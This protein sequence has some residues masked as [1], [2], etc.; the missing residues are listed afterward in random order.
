[1]IIM[2]IAVIASVGFVLG[3]QLA[4][5]QAPFRYR[6]Y[7][8]QSSAASVVKIS[9]TRA[10]DLKTLH[11]RP[12]TIQRLEWRAP[13]V[14]AGTESADPVREILFSFYDDQLY[15]V[16]VVYDRDRME[17]LT[18]DDVIESMSA[19]YGVP[20]LRQTRTGLGAVNADVN[21]DTTVVA[22]W[23]DA[24]SLLT[25]TRSTYSPQFQL[26][27]MSKPLNERARAA[28]KEALRLDTQEA[29]QREIDQRKRDVADAHV[30]SQKARVINKAAFR[31]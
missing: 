3:S 12:S 11:E 23:E 28:I 25:L 24:A 22:Q 10:A 17:G 20:L 6:E 26:V 30:A 27:L 21:A 8:L 18:S 16:V 1:M 5:A 9:A 19:T 15:Q 2:R 14:G 29:P 4:W 13:Y 7:A 31:P